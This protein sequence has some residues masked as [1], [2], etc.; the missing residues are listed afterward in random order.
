M[1]APRNILKWAAI[2]SAS[3]LGVIFIY[4]GL[5]KIVA[6]PEPSFESGI[7]SFKM[8]EGGIRLLPTQDF[9]KAIGNYNLLPGAANRALAATLPWLEIAAGLALFTRRFRYE[10]ALAITAMLWM[11]VFALTHAI[12]HNLDIACGCFSVSSRAQKL[13]VNTLLFDIALLAMV[14]IVIWHCEMQHRE[15]RRETRQ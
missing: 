9:A 14:G 5:T 7:P 8:P 12:R 6:L 4:A 10:G 11:F 15:N 1:D 3:V 2:L 13:G